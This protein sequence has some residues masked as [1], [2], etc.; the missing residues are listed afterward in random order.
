MA[1]PSTAPSRGQYCQ[2]IRGTPPRAESGQGLHRLSGAQSQTISSL[3][4]RVETSRVPSGV[5]AIR[6]PPPAPPNRRTSFPV[7]RSQRISSLAED[8]AR[9]LSFGEKTI[10][11]IGSGV[12][13]QGSPFAGFH[14]GDHDQIG[15][16]RHGDQL[17]EADRPILTGVPAQF[18]S[19]ERTA[20]PG[21]VSTR[22]WC[23]G[24]FGQG[25]QLL[26]IRH[27][28]ITHCAVEFQLRTRAARLPNSRLQKL[29]GGGVH[30]QKNRPSWERTMV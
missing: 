10:S 19:R 24:G 8:E 1:P 9:N 15:I 23:R 14:K 5:N 16:I 30:E 7:T 25:Q 22:F 12:A 6:P 26:A 27:Q 21:S 13:V 20:M 28:Q 18:H 11:V 3:S 2:H 17:P 29:V 4:V